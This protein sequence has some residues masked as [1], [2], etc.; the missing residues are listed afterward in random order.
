[1]GWW[2]CSGRDFAWKLCK[3]RGTLLYRK[4]PVLIIPLVPETFNAKYTANYTSYRSSVECLLNSCEEILMLSNLRSK[5]LF[6]ITKHFICRPYLI[7]I[8][9]MRNKMFVIQKKMIC[10]CEDICDITMPP[11]AL[12]HNA[13]LRKN[14]SVKGSRAEKTKDVRT[15]QPASGA[16]S[17]Y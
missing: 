13:V 12:Y 10:N 9:S 7:Q 17:S 4:V 15:L 8:P 16:E 1:M 3:T 5:H 6:A 11:N 2:G 14:L